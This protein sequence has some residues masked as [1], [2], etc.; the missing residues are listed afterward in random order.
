MPPHPIAAAPAPKVEERRFDDLAALAAA[1]RAK[2]RPT[3]VCPSIDGVA[4]QSMLN[5]LDAAVLIARIVAAR[6]SLFPAALQNLSAV[7]DATV[8]ARAVMSAI[9]FAEHPAAFP[10]ERP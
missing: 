10:N 1:D 2:S 8:D 5:H 4:L 7:I 9:V 3:P 6:G